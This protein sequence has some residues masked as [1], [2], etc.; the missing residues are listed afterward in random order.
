ML[1]FPRLK[2]AVLPDF[3]IRLEAESVNGHEENGWPYNLKDNGRQNQVRLKFKTEEKHTLSG[4]E[5]ARESEQDKERQQRKS[6]HSLE[7]RRRG[8]VSITRKGDTKSMH[9][10]ETRRQ[11]KHALPRDE[12]ARKSEQDKHGRW[13]KST[14]SLETRR[15]KKD[16]KARKSEQDKNGRWG[17]S[18]HSLGREGEKSEQDKNG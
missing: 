2:K 6:T 12:K 18:M 8:K 16:E 13:G 4:D 5:K 11:R 1:V 17:K 7:A 9:F 3:G 15:R 10:L 14:H